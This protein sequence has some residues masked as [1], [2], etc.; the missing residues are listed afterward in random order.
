L[1]LAVIAALGLAFRDALL[2]MGLAAL[3]AIPADAR[4]DSAPSSRGPR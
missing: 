4:R 2:L 1:L 3:L